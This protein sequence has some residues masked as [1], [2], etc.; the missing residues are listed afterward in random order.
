ME[1]PLIALFT[2]SRSS[3]CPHI[4]I[5]SG[6][7]ELEDKSERKVMFPR[8]RGMSIAVV[9]LYCDVSGLMF[10]FIKKNENKIPYFP[11]YSACVICIKKI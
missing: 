5:Y 10:H 6:K 1:C 9:G 2:V 7:A 4:L 8:M 11:A 3:C